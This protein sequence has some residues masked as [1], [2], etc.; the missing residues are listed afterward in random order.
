MVLVEDFRLEG[1][2]PE[3][4]LVSQRTADA[5]CFNLG[6]HKPS[7]TPAHDEKIAQSTEQNG[8]GRCDAEH[9]PFAEPSLDDRLV[10]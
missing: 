9:L 3:Q 7:L 2:S 5:D 8:T 10:S 1:S 6:S 4:K